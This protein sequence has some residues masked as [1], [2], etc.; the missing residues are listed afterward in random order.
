VDSSSARN[1]TLRAPRPAPRGASAPPKSLVKRN[2]K[3]RRRVPRI[4]CP[5]RRGARAAGTRAGRGAGGAG[6]GRGAAPGSD[7]LEVGERMLEARVAD[8]GAALGA[9]G[10]Q[11]LGAR[12]VREHREQP[13]LRRLLER[14]HLPARA[15]AGKGGG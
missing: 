4:R 9:R 1:A 8:A 2:L 15:E 14:S 13:V 5:G 7:G 11:E 10:A 3:S 12:L 6:R